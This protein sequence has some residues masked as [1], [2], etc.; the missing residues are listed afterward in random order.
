MT[1]MH[2]SYHLH[3]VHYCLPGASDDSDAYHDRTAG[4]TLYRGAFM[5]AA[6]AVQDAAQGAMV[7]IS[8]STFEQVGE[9]CRGAL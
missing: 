4:R 9:M 8:E 1:L 5:A 3:L 6:K 2:P 7:L